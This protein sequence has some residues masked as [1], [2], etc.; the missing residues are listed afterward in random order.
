MDDTTNEAND[1]NNKC[2]YGTL[3][4]GICGIVTVVG[5]IGTLIGLGVIGS[6][7]SN[8]DDDLSS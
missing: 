7:N 5:T 4:A 1:G 3:A 2:F 8:N 6:N